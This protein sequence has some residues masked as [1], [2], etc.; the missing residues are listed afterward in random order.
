MIA[1][2]V[3][4]NAEK[5]CVAG[6]EGLGVLDALIFSAHRPPHP[7]KQLNRRYPPHELVLEVGGL[8]SA[9]DDESI[10]HLKWLRRN[11]QVGDEVVIKIKNLQIVDQPQKLLKDDPEFLMNAKKR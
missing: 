9:Q 10:Q 7:D 8:R 5:L 3:K 4:V 2:E 11:L 1:F 6:V